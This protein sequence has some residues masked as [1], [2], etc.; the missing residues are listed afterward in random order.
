VDISQKR[1]KEKRKN[2]FKIHK[3]QST[4][5][6]RFNK[7]KGPS[8]DASV[9]LGREKKAI[10]NG[11]GGKSLRGKMDTWEDGEVMGGRGEPD[12]LLGEGKGLKP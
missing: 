6:K 11:E 12:L 5:F 3:I 10:T 8:E 2:P 1:K 9:P 4:E 7:L